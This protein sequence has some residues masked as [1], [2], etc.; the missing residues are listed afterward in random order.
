MKFPSRR[1]TFVAAQRRARGLAQEALEV[2]P[3]EEGA[4][5]VGD[6]DA[7]GEEEHAGVRHLDH[8]QPHVLQDAQPMCDVTAEVDEA[9]QLELVHIGGGN[10]G[11]SPSVWFRGG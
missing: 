6:V 3:E 1:E 10:K 9:E 7:L 5:D 8:E 4:G 11:R 2:S